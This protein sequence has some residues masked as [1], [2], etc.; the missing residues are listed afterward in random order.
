MLVC[1]P[2]LTEAVFLLRR[3]PPARDALLGLLETG[4]L[5]IAFRVAEHVKELRALVSMYRD[6]RVSLAHACIVRMA[7]LYDRHAAIH[8]SA[9]S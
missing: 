6:R 3:F 5:R 1:E 9:L 2:V 7:E 8:P 4:A